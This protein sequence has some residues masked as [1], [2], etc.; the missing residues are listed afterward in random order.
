MS[1]SFPGPSPPPPINVSVLCTTVL[2]RTTTPLASVF[3][4]QCLLFPEPQPLPSLS[5][6]T[7]TIM[8]VKQLDHDGQRCPCQRI[9]YRHQNKR[10]ITIQRTNAGCTTPD[11]LMGANLHH[12]KNRSSF[13]RFCSRCNSATARVPVSEHETMCTE[14]ETVEH[15]G[16]GQF[17]YRFADPAVANR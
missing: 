12:R 6:H 9:A 15:A 10:S 13:H 4:L 1:W 16:Q 11:I 8:P 14:L 5:Q 3:S 7:G 2:P 17:G